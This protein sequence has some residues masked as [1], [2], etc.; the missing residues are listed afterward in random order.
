V[1]YGGGQ[2]CSS[3]RMPASGKRLSAAGLASGLSLA[4]MLAATGTRL[5]TSSAMAT[6]TVTAVEPVVAEA[7][8]SKLLG[9]ITG[10]SAGV[11]ASGGASQEVA[12]RSLAYPYPHRGN[13]WCQWHEVSLTS[14]M[15]PQLNRKVILVVQNDVSARIWAE[16][17]LARVVEAEHTLLENI[18]PQ[19]VIQHIATTAA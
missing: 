11:P 13:Q 1:M 14:F 5:G 18:F 9:G 17:Q 12:K 3:N 4:A 2:Q 8:S 6:A 10:A 7:V 19:H 15:H 16:R